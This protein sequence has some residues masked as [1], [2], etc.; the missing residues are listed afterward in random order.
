MLI[1]HLTLQIKRTS[2]PYKNF[3]GNSCVKEL[4]A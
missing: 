1:E 3:V 2:N 4:L